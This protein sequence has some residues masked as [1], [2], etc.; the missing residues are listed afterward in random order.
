MAPKTK[1]VA[2][3]HDEVIEGSMYCK[4]RQKC[5]RGAGGGGIRRL[6]EHL[7]G[8]KGQVRSCKAPLDVIGHIREEMQKVLNDYQVCK[9][10]EKA[11]Q[12]EIGERGQPTPLLIMRTLHLFILPV[13]DIENLFIVFLLP[14]IVKIPSLCLKVKGG[15]ASKAISH[16]P[17]LL[18]LTMP[19]F[20]KFNPLNVN[21]P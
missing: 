17:P 9:A 11:I 20:L 3:V 1:D 21:P 19:M 12:D 13:L 2:W 6:E 4:Y 18:A 16:L 14:L 15:I 5:I 7:A 8:V 10:R